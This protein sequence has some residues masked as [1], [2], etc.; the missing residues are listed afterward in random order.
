MTNY[1]NKILKVKYLKKYSVISI[2]ELL[3][4]PPPPQCLFL[5]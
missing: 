5:K 3:D 1:A 4:P 2:M